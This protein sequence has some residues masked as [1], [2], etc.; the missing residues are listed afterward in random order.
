M[1]R[2][3]LPTFRVLLSLFFL[4]AIVSIA[5][6]SL[7][8]NGLVA[9]SAASAASKPIAVVP[10]EL[11]HNRVYLPV[12]VNG[13]EPYTMIL[14]TGAA[15]TFVSKKVAEELRLTRQ[16]SA[17]VRGN[18]EG[19]AHFPLAKN[20]NFSV[21]EAALLEKMIVIYNYDDLE[22]HEGRAIDGTL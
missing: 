14:D 21:G 13:S 3:T 5:P 17:Q 4:A 1:N 12:R 2:H 15:E 9:A 7:A 16:G 19:V 20:V 8:Q 6:E 22:K 10:F 11:Y 18:G